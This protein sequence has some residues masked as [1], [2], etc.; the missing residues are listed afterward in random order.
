MF[1]CLWLKSLLRTHGWWFSSYFLLFSD[2]ILPSYLQPFTKMSSPAHRPSAALRT[3]REDSS[4]DEDW[5]SGTIN[6]YAPQTSSDYNST[7]AKEVFPSIKETR[8]AAASIDC[9]SVTTSP[10][11]VNLTHWPLGDFSLNLRKVIFKLI[12]V[13]GGWGIS[14]EIALRWMPQDLTDDK[15]TL[16]QVMAWCLQATSHYLSQCWP[17]STSPNGVTRHQWVKL[18]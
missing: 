10:V 6:P 8:L 2:F 14:Y 15:S 17:R 3:P 16:V 18:P 5:D 9:D 7:T 12:L 4:G 11:Q 13:N 1:Q